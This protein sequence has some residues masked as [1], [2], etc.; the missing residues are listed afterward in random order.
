MKIK[1]TGNFFIDEKVN[2]PKNLINGMTPQKDFTS[3]GFPTKLGEYL[4]TG[5]PVICTNVSE[6]PYYLDKTS[7]ILIDP[8][9]DL[10]IYNAIEF[11]IKNLIECKS[12]GIMGQKVVQNNFE[13]KKHINSLIKYL[14]L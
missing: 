2:N 3:G 12:I 4:S 5:N 8:K 6:I 14:K 10:L 13:V 9:D 7:A 1:F 11:V